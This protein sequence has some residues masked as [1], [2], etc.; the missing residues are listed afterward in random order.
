MN[1]SE[2]EILLV[3]DNPTDV[4]LTLHALRYNCVVNRIHVAGD[5]EEALDFIFCRGLHATRS[6]Q[7]LPK[8]ILLDLRLPKVDGIEVLHAIKSHEMTRLIPVVALTSCGEEADLVK[9]YQLGVNSY[10]QK[11]VDFVQ[12]RETV[13]HLG[14][15]W[16]VV[17]EPSPAPAPGQI[18]DNG[19]RHVDSK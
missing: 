6:P 9:S 15:F 7:E 5:G 8:L 18:S 2:I 10:I 16:M 11:P 4:E 1:S 14:L 13:R 12:F 3:E 17:N 19:I